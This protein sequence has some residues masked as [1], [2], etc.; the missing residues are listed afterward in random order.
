MRCSRRASSDVAESTAAASVASTAKVSTLTLSTFV[1]GSMVGAGIFSL[2]GQFSASTGAAGALLTWA[3]AGTGTLMLALVFQRLAVQAPHLDAG[4]FAYA[5]AGFGDYLGFIA[6]FGY[7]AS[8]VAGNVFYWVFV[9]STLGAVFPALGDGDTP[10]AIL[11]ASAG[12]W[13]FYAL[14]RR[15]VT[16][17]AA[18]NRVVTIAKV[19]P[20]VLFVVLCVVAFD[21]AVFAANWTGGADAAPLWDQVTS[22]LLVTVFV[23][24]GIEG[25]SVYS[26]HARRRKDVG[27]ATLLGFVSVLAV[28]ASVTLVSYGV[29][30]RSELAE[31]RQPSMAAILEVAVGGWGAVFVGVAL[32]VAVLGAYLAW[33]L[34]AAEVLL[35]AARAGV[36]PR[37]LRYADRNDVPVGALTVTTALAQIMLIVVLFS[38]NAFDIALSLTS[39]LILIPYLLSAAFALKLALGAQ[40]GIRVAATVVAGLATAYTAFLLLAAGASYVLISLMLL[41][42]A[43][44]L[45]AAAKRERGERVFTRVEWVVFALAC[46][47]ALAAAVLLA[48]GSLDL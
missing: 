25:A 2:P 22:T 39:S 10:A 9:T 37:P 28:F 48:T 14:I 13:V 7:W 44:A 46:L 8:A 27:R 12:L 36:L 38:D 24:I 11:V 18:L 32:I 20:I 4:V 16:Q 1:V 3:L 23:F 29:L 21:P 47:G 42:P 19:A 6:A 40:G 34:M 15:G 41:V 33:T 45:F 43:T 31:L 17:A 5:K 26:R 35:V 30:P